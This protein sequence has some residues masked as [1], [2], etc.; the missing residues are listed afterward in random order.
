MIP[1]LFAVMASL[2]NIWITLQICPAVILVGLSLTYSI[3]CTATVV[4]CEVAWVA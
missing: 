1:D 3:A 4:R 2:N